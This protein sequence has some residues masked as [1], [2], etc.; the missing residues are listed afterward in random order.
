MSTKIRWVAPQMLVLSILTGGAHAADGEAAL[1]AEHCRAAIS[2]SGPQAP[3]PP[4][5]DEYRFLFWINGRYP[6]CEFLS[7]EGQ[8][9]HRIL[10]AQLV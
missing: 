5:S 2:F 7:Q 10:R 8:V 6:R 9:R 1:F 4:S 3:G